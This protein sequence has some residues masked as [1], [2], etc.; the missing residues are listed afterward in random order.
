MGEGG[1]KKLFHV[2]VLYFPPMTWLQVITQGCLE[3]VF[4]DARLLLR[5]LVENIPLGHPW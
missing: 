3:P 4:G 2:T 1:G 5:D